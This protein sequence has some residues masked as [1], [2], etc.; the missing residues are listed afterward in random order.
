MMSRT[1][2]PGHPVLHTQL[3]DYIHSYNNEVDTKSRATVRS[4]EEAIVNRGLYSHSKNL[5]IFI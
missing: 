5:A 3:A 1:Y 4:F 2:K